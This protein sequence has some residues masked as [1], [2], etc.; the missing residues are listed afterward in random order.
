M[1]KELA[2]S[3]SD[4][5]RECKVEPSK[6]PSRKE[7]AEQAKIKLNNQGDSKSDKFGGVTPNPYSH[8][9]YDLKIPFPQVLERNIDNKFCKFLCIFEQLH[10]NI[11]VIEALEQ[12]PKY[13]KFLKGIL[14]KKRRLKEQ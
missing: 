10:I 5:P 8:S 7:E 14:S 11:L 4:D 2:K 6:G 1:N 9:S 13:A 12:M 3:K